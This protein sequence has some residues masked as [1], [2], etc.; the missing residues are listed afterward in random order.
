MHCQQQLRVQT[1]LFALLH[2][3]QSELLLLQKILIHGVHHREC[4]H[5][6]QLTHQ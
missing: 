6:H 5:H 4:L 3:Q 2:Q 1:E